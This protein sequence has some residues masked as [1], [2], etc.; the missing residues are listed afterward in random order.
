MA[1]TGF[2]RSWCSHGPSLPSRSESI[3]YRNILIYLCNSNRSYSWSSV[4]FVG[5]NVCTM[6]TNGQSRSVP[7]LWYWYASFL[8]VSKLVSLSPFEYAIAV[9]SLIWQIPINNGVDWP[10]KIFGALGLTMIAAGLVPPYIDIYKTR[11]V[12]GF[13]FIFLM[14]DMGGALFSL[15]SL[16]IFFSANCT[17]Y[18][19]SKSLIF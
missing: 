2:P 15:L 11:R 17:H 1:Q 16:C 3:A 4:S 12:R 10:A 6:T 18:K 9:A 13:S 14:I 5:Y 19:S 7:S 8:E